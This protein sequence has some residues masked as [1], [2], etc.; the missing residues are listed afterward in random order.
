MKVVTNLRGE[1]I[2]L[3]D[4]LKRVGMTARNGAENNGILIIVKDKRPI[5]VVGESVMQVLTLPKKGIECNPG[6]HLCNHYPLK[7]L[8]LR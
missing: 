8:L 5:G 4:L 7:C 3:I 1:V 6:E 2:P